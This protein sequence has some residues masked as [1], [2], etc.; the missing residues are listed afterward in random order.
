MNDQNRNSTDW[1]KFATLKVV[2]IFGAIVLLIFT[3]VF[4]VGLNSNK[5]FE[6]FW[7]KFKNR[8]TLY[9]TKTEIVYKDK[10]DTFYKYFSSPNKPST[11]KVE[12]KSTSG[13]NAAVGGN[14]SGNAGNANSQDNSTHT[15]NGINSGVNG[16]VS[17]SNERELSQGDKDTL[18]HDIG[19]YRNF[20]G[21]KSKDIAF[22]ILLNSNMQKWA[23]QAREFLTKS[24]YSCL[25][26]SYIPGEFKNYA[27]N[28]NPDDSSSLVIYVGVNMR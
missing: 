24:G 2:I 23:V 4:I 16:N 27:V 13:D 20:R 18:I 25:N 6:F 26:T 1:S 19:I 21:I 17:I 5:N 15:V 7:V 11:V 12:Q 10:I 9:L 22:H 8:D 3:A 28:I 14:N